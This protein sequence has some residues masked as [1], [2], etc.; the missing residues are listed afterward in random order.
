MGRLRWGC[1][2]G[3]YRNCRKLQRFIEVLHCYVFFIEA[4][5]GDFSQGIDRH[6]HRRL[7]GGCQPEI[8]RCLSPSRL[9]FFGSLHRWPCLE[10][11][12]LSLSV[13]WGLHLA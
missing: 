4:G 8:E 6:H 11:S 13:G 3:R 2:G 12:Q 1:N 7:L 5:W 10:L 9:F